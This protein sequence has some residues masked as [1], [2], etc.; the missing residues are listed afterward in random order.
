[1]EAAPEA[2]LTVQQQLYRRLC[3]LMKQPDIFTDPDLDRARLAQLLG[4]NEHYVS[5]AISACADGKSVNGFL[6]EYRVRH[7]ARL[8]ATTTDSVVLIAELSGFSRSS[9]FRIFSDVYGMSPSD[10]RKVAR[11]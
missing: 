9:F 11:K 4:T 1:M 3:E 8:L 6:N 7:A 2:D 10:Y 5:D